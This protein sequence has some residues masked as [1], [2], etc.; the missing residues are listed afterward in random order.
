MTTCVE[1]MPAATAVVAP[2]RCPSHRNMVL[3]QEM[4]RTRA[5]AVQPLSF[6]CHRWPGV[7]MA[8]AAA[9]VAAACA[10]A[11]AAVAATFAAAVAAAAG[12]G[13]AR[14]NALAQERHDSQL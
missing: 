12:T 13:S 5:T 11:V 10:A 6:L 14:G 4:A 8:A 1:M 3:A 2:C 9:T 7:E